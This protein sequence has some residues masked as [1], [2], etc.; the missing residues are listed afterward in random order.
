MK[1]L[2]KHL[3]RTLKQ[4]TIGQRQFEK[5]KQ[6]IREPISHKHSKMFNLRQFQ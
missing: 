6:K 1:Q 5:R 2:D 3:H 4:S